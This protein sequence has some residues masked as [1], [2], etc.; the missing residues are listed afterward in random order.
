MRALRSVI[1]DGKAAGII[2]Q[3]QYPF[4]INNNGK[5]QIPEGEGRKLALTASQLIEV[6]NYQILPEDERWRDLW[7][8]SFYCN[9]ININDLLRL[10]FK[11]IIDGEI[12]WFRQR[13]L[14]RIGKKG[15]SGP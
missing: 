13:L 7:V 5:Y 2:S 10:K 9:G 11:N 4:V 6:F 14:N 8:F 15:K 1:N 12:V 3:V